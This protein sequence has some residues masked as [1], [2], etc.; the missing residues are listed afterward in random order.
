MRSFGSKSIKYIET[1]GKKCKQDDLDNIYNDGYNNGIKNISFALSGKKNNLKYDIIEYDRKLKGTRF[2]GKNKKVKS[3]EIICS[4]IKLI[5]KVFCEG[6]N[7][8]IDD[9]I[10]TIKETTGIDL[11][12]NIDRNCIVDPKYKNPIESIVIYGVNFD[13]KEK[14]K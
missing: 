6:F 13:E 9:V 7:D 2:R 14:K 10:N 11:N 4:S 3:G 1:D 12:N 8:A 5:D